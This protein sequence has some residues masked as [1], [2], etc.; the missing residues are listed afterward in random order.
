[1]YWLLRLFDAALFNISKKIVYFLLFVFSVFLILATLGCFYFLWSKLSRMMTKSVQNLIF[2]HLIQRDKWFFM[3]HHIQHIHEYIEKGLLICT[4]MVERLVP[5]IIVLGTIAFFGMLAVFY[6]T[7]TLGIILIMTTIP[8]VWINYAL[9]KNKDTSEKAGENAFNTIMDHQKYLLSIV[10][11]IQLLQYHPMIVKKFSITQEN[12]NYQE[13][14]QTNKIIFSVFFGITT[15]LVV[16][17]FMV[18]LFFLLRPLYWWSVLEVNFTILVLLGYLISTNRLIHFFYKIKNNHHFIVQWF[19]SMMYYKPLLLKENVVCKNNLD[20]G[21]GTFGVHH[22]S[23]SYPHRPYATLLD[24]VT[25]CV[26]PNQIVAIT[27][28]HPPYLEGFF[29]LLMRFF[30]PQK[31][32]FY[33][34][35]SDYGELSSDSVREKIT[36]IRQCPFLYTHNLWDNL[37]GGIHT[38]YLKEKVDKALMRVDLF[39]WKESFIHGYDTFFSSQKENKNYLSPYHRCKIAFARHLIRGST[40]AFIDEHK[41]RSELKLTGYKNKI[42]DPILEKTTTIIVTDH[43]H[44]ILKAHKIIVFNGPKLIAEGSHYDLINTCSSYRGLIA[45]SKM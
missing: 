25:F 13:M 34:D 5:T 40:M 17:F 15:T 20:S 27:G 9:A 10:E 30:L 21:R 35:G 2:S 22:V 31:G 44:T 11:D 41:L 45:N 36:T 1:M 8:M 24:D 42:L 12:V 28:L 19:E 16:F 4:H 6:H 33:I 23:F 18:G 43:I 39:D 7:I 38:T 37:V 32:N 3:T 14:E 26:A 29:Q